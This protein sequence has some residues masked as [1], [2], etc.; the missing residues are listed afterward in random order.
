MKY[1]LKISYLLIFIFVVS[2]NSSTTV[3]EKPKEESKELTVEEALHLAEKWVAEQGY[4]ADSTAVNKQKIV[5]EVGEYASDTSKIVKL[6]HNTLQP[7]G[8]VAQEYQGKLGKAWMIGFN[9]EPPENNIVR[10][11]TMD[12]IGHI[13]NMQPQ[14]VRYDWMVKGG[15]N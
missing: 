10:V 6:R 13:I 2:C 8:R 11:V 3:E 14:D 7:Q 12:S 9:Y 15:N 4:T 1:C 5:F